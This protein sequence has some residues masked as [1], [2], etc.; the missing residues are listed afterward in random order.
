MP[1]VSLLIGWF[2]TA[3][4]A[5]VRR[6]SEGR[7]RQYDVRHDRD[8]DQPPRHCR[9]TNANDFLTARRR[10]VNATAVPRQRIAHRGRK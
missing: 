1:R 10:Q 6:R 5:S 3:D 8:G 4:D 7:P 9:V 2:D